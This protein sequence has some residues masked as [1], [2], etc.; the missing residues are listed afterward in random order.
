MLFRGD[1]VVSFFTINNTRDGLV[2]IFDE[3]KRWGAR[4]YDGLGS[5]FP[6]G[7]WKQGEVGTYGSK[8]PTR[9]EIIELDG[10]DHCLTFRWTVGDGTGRNSNNNY[11]FC[12]NKGFT[13]YESNYL[14]NQ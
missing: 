5:K 12:P 4:T 14:T 3:R 13:K 10:V 7:Y 9:V 2:R 11:T 1:K 8:R 6:L